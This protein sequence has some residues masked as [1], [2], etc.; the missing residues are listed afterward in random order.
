MLHLI[1]TLTLD[2]HTWHGYGGVAEEA[3]EEADGVEDS[4]GAVLHLTFIPGGN[5]FLY[6]RNM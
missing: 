2:F 6:W 4:D 3:G 5:Q 1:C